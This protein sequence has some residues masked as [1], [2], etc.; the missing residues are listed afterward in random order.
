MSPII[1]PPPIAHRPF[2]IRRRSPEDMARIAEQERAHGDLL[3]LIGRVLRDAHSL[4]DAGAQVVVLGD[5]KK[6]A[7]EVL[8]ETARDAL[9]NPPEGERK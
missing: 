6:A 7:A 1:E 5:T 8:A 4:T 2:V 3:L 9:E